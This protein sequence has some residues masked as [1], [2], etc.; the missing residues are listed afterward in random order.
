MADRLNSD[1]ISGTSSPALD[2]QEMPH[3]SEGIA[4]LNL[5]LI[6]GEHAA[7]WT[8]DDVANYL[9]M[10]VK[11]I[12]KWRLTGDGPVGA[13]LGKHL[14]YDPADVVAWFESQKHAA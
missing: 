5:S 13:R 10:P 6:E 1:H 14:R 3:M 9:R 11:T 4:E 7:R 8:V 2:H 12:Y